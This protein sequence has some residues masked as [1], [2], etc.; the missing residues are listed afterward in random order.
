MSLQDQRRAIKE[1][2]ARREDRFMEL[3]AE[4]AGYNKAGQLQKPRGF[5]KMYPKTWKAIYDSVLIFANE[6]DNIK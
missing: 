2:D 5:K 4:H 6:V 1:R 3:L